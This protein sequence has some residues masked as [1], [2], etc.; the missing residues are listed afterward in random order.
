M[1]FFFDLV[2][3]GLWI[4]LALL[5]SAFAMCGRAFLIPVRFQLNFTRLVASHAGCCF[6]VCIYCIPVMLGVRLLLV[7]AQVVPGHRFHSPGC[8]HESISLYRMVNCSSLG[9]FEA[10][11]IG[12]PLFWLQLFALDSDNS[13][14]S[15]LL[16]FSFVKFEELDESRFNACGD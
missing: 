7:A 2:G 15:H 6:S 4:R 14:S 13:S 1:C 12:V 10:A 5:L 3:S 9:L 8:V 11:V 16:S